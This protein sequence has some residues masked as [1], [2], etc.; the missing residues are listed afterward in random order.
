MILIKI[1]ERKLE[2][3]DSKVHMERK[4][5]GSHESITEERRQMWAQVYQ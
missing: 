2:A 4:K 5:I 1:P 3:I